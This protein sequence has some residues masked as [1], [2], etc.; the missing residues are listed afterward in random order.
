VG[1]ATDRYVGADGTNTPSSGTIGSPYRTVA[2]ACSHSSSG[3]LIH[4][5]SGT[6]NEGQITIPAGISLVGIDTSHTFIIFANIG[7]T[8]SILMQGGGSPSTVGQSISNIK[9][10]CNTSNE[11]AWGMSIYD[12]SNVIIHDCSFQDFIYC[13]IVNG[14]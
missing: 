9:F 8:P 4:I 13:G 14:Y 2:Y 6:Y 5:A 10:Y 3:D 12:R 7:N 1:F 11:A